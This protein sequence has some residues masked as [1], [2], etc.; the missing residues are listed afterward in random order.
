[1]SPNRA[2]TT[3]TQSQLKNFQ[4]RPTFKV[5]RASDSESDED[6]DDEEMDFSGA[7]GNSV[8]DFDELE[9]V[10]SEEKSQKSMEPKQPEINRLAMQAARRDWQRTETDSGSPEVQVAILTERIIYLT[11]HMQTNPKDFHSR[12]GLI[13]M[14]NKRKT[15]LEFYFTQSPEKCLKL[16]STLGIRFRPRRAVQSREQKYA[17]FKNTKSKIGM[18]KA[19]ALQTKALMEKKQQQEAEKKAAKAMLRSKK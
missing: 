14:V 10:L 8:P 16:C 15:Q 1:M 17:P 4:V 6:S 12:R 7:E 18:K 19:A 3:I 11:K 5:L 2:I 9:F 13:A